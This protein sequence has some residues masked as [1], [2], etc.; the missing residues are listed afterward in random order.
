MS[1][2]NSLLGSNGSSSSS[3]SSSSGGLALTPNDFVKFLVTELQ[4]QDPTNATD[5]NQILTQ[6]SEIGQL[7]SS[8]TLQTDLTGLVQQNQI[9][10]AGG[11]IGKL[12]QGTDAN[13]NPQTGIVSGVQVTST[14]VNLTLGSGA[15]VPLSNVTAI[16]NA[17]TVSTAPTTATGSNAPA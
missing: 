17:P 5:P 4:N 12:I 14:G 10:S 3:S 9:S 13:Q 16:T 11:L 6:V 2:I 15:S 1:A 8:T 7:Q